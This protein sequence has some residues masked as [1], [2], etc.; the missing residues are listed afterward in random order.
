MKLE[1]IKSRIRDGNSLSQFTNWYIF[2]DLVIHSLKHL[3]SFLYAYV[4]LGAKA[5]EINKIKSL[6]QD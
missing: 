1:K 2:I 4:V 3:L 6:T 5:T